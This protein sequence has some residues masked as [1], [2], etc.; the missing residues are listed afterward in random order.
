MRSVE[1]EINFPIQGKL[2]TFRESQKPFL[3]WAGGKSQL[4][5]ELRKYIPASFNKYIEPFVGGGSVFLH[6]HPKKSI[7]SEPSIRKSIQVVFRW[8]YPQSGI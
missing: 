1:K 3:K 2:G 4:L 8:N 7:I 6:I 5:P